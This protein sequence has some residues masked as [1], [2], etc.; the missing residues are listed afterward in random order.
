MAVKKFLQRVH[1]EQ[2]PTC[3]ISLK[4]LLAA[5]FFFKFPLLL[6]V[7]LFFADTAVPYGHALQKVF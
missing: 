2:F 3:S 1:Y 7:K 6:H 4:R 5:D